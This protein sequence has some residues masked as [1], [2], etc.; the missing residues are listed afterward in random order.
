M[1]VALGL[2]A[3]REYLLDA[4]NPGEIDVL[5]D[6]TAQGCQLRACHWELPHAVSK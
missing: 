1:N 2:P 6:G 3:H 4:L 5:I